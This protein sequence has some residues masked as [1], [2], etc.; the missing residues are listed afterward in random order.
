M[1]MIPSYGCHLN[2]SLDG[3]D[4]GAPVILSHFLGGRLETFDGQM[5]VLAGRRVVRFDTRGHGASDAPPGDYDVAMLGQDVLAIMHA[6]SIERADFVGVSQ[7]GMTGMWLAS[8][9]PGRIDRLVLANTTPFI[10]NKSVWDELAAKAEEEGLAQIAR[11][12]ILGWLSDGFIEAHA[13]EVERLVLGMAAM[14][15]SGYVGNTRVL[16]DVDLRASLARIEAPTLVIGGTEDGPRGASVP[17]ITQGVKDGRSVLIPHAAH[18]SNVE[19]PA[20]FNAAL[21]EHLRLR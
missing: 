18:I 6:L 13:Q 4:D 1:P 7:G 8:E 9:H 21:A 10:P 19:N 2:V 5:P 20:A 16:R 14:P 17:I 15:V 11:V 12:T 3:P